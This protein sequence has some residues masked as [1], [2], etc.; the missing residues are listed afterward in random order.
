MEREDHERLAE[1]LDQ[2]AGRL[3]DRSEELGQQIDRTRSDWHAKQT[4]AGV[5]GAVEPAGDDGPQD[6]DDGDG[7]ADDEDEEDDGDEE[8][9]EDDEDDGDEE[10][11]DEDDGNGRSER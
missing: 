4:D 9:D 2:E 8:D 3:E 1:K 11:E 5:P 10:D 6:S 7:R